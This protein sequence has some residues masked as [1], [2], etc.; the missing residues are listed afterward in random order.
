MGVSRVDATDPYVIEENTSTVPLAAGA[1]FTGDWARASDGISVSME[2]D[3]AGTL[4]F[5][6][7][8]DAVNA[9]STFTDNQ[10]IVQALPIG[11]SGS[12]IIPF[13]DITT[14]QPGETYTIAARTVTGTSTWTIATLN[15]REDQ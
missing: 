4:F 3:Q 11:Q 1:T 14:L 15:T 2:T 12:V 5:A 9:D 13:E 6:F 7:S 8:N 10:Q